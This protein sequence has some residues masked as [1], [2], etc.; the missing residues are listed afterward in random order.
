MSDMICVQKVILRQMSPS[1]AICRSTTS[2]DGS[3]PRITRVLRGGEGMVFIWEFG[4]EVWY[5]LYTMCVPKVV[6]GIGI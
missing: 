6:D 2:I 1:R 3:N 4:V 5:T